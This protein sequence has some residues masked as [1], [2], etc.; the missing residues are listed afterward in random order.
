MKSLW[1]SLNLVS[2]LVI[3]VTLSL[4]NKHPIVFGKHNKKG[5][6]HPKPGKV[7][8]PAEPHVPHH[9]KPGEPKSDATFEIIVINKASAADTVNVSCTPGGGPPGKPPAPTCGPPVE[10]HLLKQGERFSWTFDYPD[11][12]TDI[13]YN[14]KV[15]WTGHNQ[16]LVSFFD[17]DTYTDADCRSDKGN[18]CYWTIAPDGFYFS[19]EDAPFPGPAWTFRWPWG[20]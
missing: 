8:H 7:D 16:G 15:D 10:P 9:G 20:T 13:S 17:K 18:H 3:I 2:L 12:K 11:A 6:H 14:C 4:V 5:G 1:P 19:N